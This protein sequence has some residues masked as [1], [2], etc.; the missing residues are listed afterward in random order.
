MRGVRV[1]SG[2]G[3][4]LKRIGVIAATL[5]AVFC[6]VVHAQQT[7]AVV[8]GD[9]GLVSLP[10]A[11]GPFSQPVENVS[12]TFTANPA[13]DFQVNPNSIGP[14]TIQPGTTHEFLISYT[15][16]PNATAGGPYTVTL[17]QQSSNPDAYRDPDDPAGDE[18]V[19]FTVNLTAPQM[20]AAGIV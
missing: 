19:S 8:P 5:A 11:A 3:R 10:V 7:T 17:H 9:T 2:L 14:V 20:T 13:L 4:N 15:I 1:R 12:V 18:V 6:G 16:G